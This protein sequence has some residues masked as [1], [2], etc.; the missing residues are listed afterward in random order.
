MDGIARLDA[1]SR[2]HD[3]TSCMVAFSWVSCVEKLPLDKTTKETTLG[4]QKKLRLILSGVFQLIFSHDFKRFTSLDVAGRNPSNQKKLHFTRIFQ[5][6]SFSDRV[7]HTLQNEFG[8]TFGALESLEV[9]G[10]VVE[11]E[12]IK[13]F[14]DIL[15]K[16]EVPR[17]FLWIFFWPA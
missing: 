10:N 6:F 14:D 12:S 3:R 2:S 4:P 7:F 11:V 16:N 15:A 8:K 13:A 1:D 17:Q 9:A 5:H